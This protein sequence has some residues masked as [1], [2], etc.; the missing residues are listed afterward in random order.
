MNKVQLTDK[1]M[2]QLVNL[3]RTVDEALADFPGRTAA[4]V[5]QA[6]HSAYLSL[7]ALQHPAAAP[8]ATVAKPKTKAKTKQK[9]KQP[10][11]AVGSTGERS[12]SIIAVIGKSKKPM[13]AGDIAKQLEI[14]SQGLGPVL[15]KMHNDG[16]LSKKKVDDSTT[17]WGSKALN[18]KSTTSHAN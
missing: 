3:G 17:L 1:Q 14:P 11:K 2:G 12:A 10:K 13:T 4:D 7:R 16:L 18:G 15:N 6:A 8:K 9:Q 5:A